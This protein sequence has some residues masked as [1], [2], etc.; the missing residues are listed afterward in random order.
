[1]LNGQYIKHFEMILEKNDTGSFYT[2]ILI[3][4]LGYVDVKG[5]V[6]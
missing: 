1:M 3:P 2:L 4:R 6:Y 5:A